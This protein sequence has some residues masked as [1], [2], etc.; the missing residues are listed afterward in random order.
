MR[1]RVIFNNKLLPYL[2]LVPQMAITIVFFFLPAG[3]AI[4]Q[5]VLLQDPFG[6]RSRFVWFENF[7]IV[8]TDPNYLNALS[9]T[10][11]FSLS[12]TVLSMCSALLLAVVADR[13]IRGAVAYRTMLVW[14]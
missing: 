14:P 7:E 1:K 11:V 13:A 4:R 8:L 2:L 5:S 12:V 10:I 6:L 3:Q 9:N